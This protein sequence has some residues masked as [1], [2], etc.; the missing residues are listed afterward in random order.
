MRE[1]IKWEKERLAEFYTP[2][3]NIVYRPYLYQKQHDR[4]DDLG[5]YSTVEK[6][7]DAI[8]NEWDDWD[9][10]VHFTHARIYKDQIDSSEASDCVWLNMQNKVI[11]FSWYNYSRDALDDP[12]EIFIHIPLPFEKGDIVEFVGQPYVGACLLT[13]LPHWHKNYHAWVSGDKIADYTD[14]TAGVSF[15]DDDKHLHHTDGQLFLDELMFHTGGLKGHDRFLRYLSDFIKGNEKN[16]ESLLYAYDKIRAI[17]EY[18]KDTSPL[19]YCFKLWT[20]NTGGF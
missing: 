13:D 1:R 8:R 11:K 2:Q 20:E 12:S 4:G 3:A 7:I 9:N 5:C 19:D 18:E 14:M 15:M 6:S 10:S 17:S 16:P